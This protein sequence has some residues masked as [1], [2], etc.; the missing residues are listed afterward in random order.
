MKLFE[1][2]STILLVAKTLKGRNTRFVLCSLSD[3]VK[4]VFK[5]TAFDKVIEVFESRSDIIAAISASDSAL[6]SGSL[7]RSE[8][9]LSRV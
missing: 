3:P 5:I 2:T 7:L 9:I 6:S 8:L 4:E 1:Q